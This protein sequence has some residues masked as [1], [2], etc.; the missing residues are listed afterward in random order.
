MIEPRSPALQTDS[1]LSEPPGKSLNNTCMNVCEVTS[2]VSN[3]VTQWTVA[4]QTP[5]SMGFPRQKYWTGLPFPSPG[6]L[7]DPGIE[8]TSTVSPA[9]AGGL[10]YYCATWEACVKYT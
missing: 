8:L 10:F 1:L 6:H 4:C 5:L 3:S 7:P 9:M 2:V